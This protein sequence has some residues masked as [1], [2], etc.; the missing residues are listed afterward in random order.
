M[1][2][3]SKMADESL[4]LVGQGLPDSRNVQSTGIVFNQVHLLLVRRGLDSWWAMLSEVNDVKVTRKLWSPAKV[5]IHARGPHISLTSVCRLYISPGSHQHGRLVRERRALWALIP[6]HHI[7][8]LTLE[9]PIMHFKWHPHDSL[10]GSHLGPE[11][12]EPVA[13][14]PWSSSS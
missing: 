9:F 5:S 8:R 12:P 2:L 11:L 4:N 3:L 1:K 7:C 10:T 13:P 6:T 14:A